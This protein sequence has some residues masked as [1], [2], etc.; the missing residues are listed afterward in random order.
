[1]LRL[2]SICV[3]LLRLLTT[4]L[5]GISFMPSTHESI[6]SQ[7]EKGGKSEKWRKQSPVLRWWSGTESSFAAAEAGG[8]RSPVYYGRGVRNIYGLFTLEA[9]P[10]SQQ[11]RHFLV[12]RRE[13]KKKKEKEICKEST[14]KMKRNFMPSFLL[15][16][17]H[18]CFPI[19]IDTLGK[20]DTF[21]WL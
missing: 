21:R 9:R 6:Q 8:S 18:L 7:K 13:K 12:I 16:V 15:S 3:H 4:T 5:T 11:L 10:L 1:M 17:R 20:A 2:L 19:K 14:N